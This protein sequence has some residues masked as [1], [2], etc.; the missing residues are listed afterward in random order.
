[1]DG[2]KKDKEGQVNKGGGMKGRKKEDDKCGTRC[3]WC[4]ERMYTFRKMANLLCLCLKIMLT[5]LLPHS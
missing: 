4:R 1:V 3:L 2:K 5:C